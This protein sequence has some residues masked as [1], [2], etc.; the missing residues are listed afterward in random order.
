[1][2]RRP[3]RSTLFP[4]TTLFRAARGQSRG[5]P[6][7]AQGVSRLLGPLELQILVGWGVGVAPDQAD[8]GLLETRPDAPGERQLVD[9]DVRY[10]IVQDLL[11]LVD[12]CL[13]PLHVDL[14]RLTLEQVLDLRNDAGRVRAFLADVRLQARGGVAR[15]PRDAHDQILELLLSPGGR[16]GRPLHD[17]DAR[18]DADRLEIGGE[19]FAHRRVRR[20]RVEVAGVESVGIARLRHELLGSRGIERGWLERFRE[21]E[22]AGDDAAGRLREPERLRLVERRAID[23]VAGRQA[24]APVGPRGLRIPLIGHVEPEDAARL[25]RRGEL[26]ARRPS[27]V[28]GDGPGQQVRDVDLA[29]LEGGGPR[30]LLGPAPEHESVHARRLAP[31]AFVSLAPR[32][33]ARV[34]AHELVG[35][36]AD[37]R[38]LEAVVAHL[39]DV[40]L[41][42]DPAR[43]GRRCTVERH[44]IRP[45]FLEHEPDATGIHDLNFA[46]AVFQE[47]HAGAAVAIVGKLHVLRRD[48]IAVVELDTLAEHELIGQ[49]V[50]RLAPRLG[51]APRG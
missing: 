13:A 12:Q 6:R 35:P 45:R 4:Y 10:P 49:S 19:R 40:L 44:E 46:H 20:P 47:L 3:P 42:H 18:L 50:L 32:L 51:Q 7:R 1:M 22:R 43:P 15:R 8:A 33:H 11:D 28:L 14:A 37:R 25:A 27:N 29:L 9:R 2:I 39:L 5:R 38:L 41:R 26:E 23:R 17:P 36:G 16:E 34:E 24:D 48:R 30:G 31:V 21:L